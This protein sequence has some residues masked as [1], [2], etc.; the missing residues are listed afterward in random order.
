MKRSLPLLGV[1]TIAVAAMSLPALANDHGAMSMGRGGRAFGA[2]RH[3]LSKIDLTADQKAAVEAIFSS[4]KDMLQA[5][6][7]TLRTD[8]EKLQSD[9]ASGADSSAIGRDTLTAHADQ[10]KL[11][12]DVA[13]V[14]SQVL[15]KLNA[16]QQNTV[17]AC[18]A[19]LAPARSNSSESS[20][21]PGQ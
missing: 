17:N 16:D 15:A 9:I 3:C 7:Q 2:V 21:G 20:S 4:S 10:T 6:M 19:A 13:S 18:L 8:H 1:A 5:D 11:K 12:N 14:K